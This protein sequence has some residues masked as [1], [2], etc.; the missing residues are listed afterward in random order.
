[1][2]IITSVSSSRH[3]ITTTSGAVIG[4]ALIWAAL[5]CRYV[6]HN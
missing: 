5:M 4:E 6:R 2:S 3:E 1:M